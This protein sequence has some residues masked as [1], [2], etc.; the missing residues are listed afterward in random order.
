MTFVRETSLS[1]FTSIPFTWKWNDSKTGKDEEGFGNRKKDTFVVERILLHP[2]K[3]FFS[4][5][6]RHQTFIL[7]AKFTNF[8]NL[9]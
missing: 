1:F 2:L 4:I 5:P 7:Y 6:F 9:F 3:A 8:G